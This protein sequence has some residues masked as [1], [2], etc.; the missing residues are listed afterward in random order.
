MSRIS[1]EMVEFRHTWI[2]QWKFFKRFSGLIDSAIGTEFCVHTLKMSAEVL[3][4][5]IFDFLPQSQNM[6]F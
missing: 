5:G 6:I 2:L 1:A 4:C 3:M